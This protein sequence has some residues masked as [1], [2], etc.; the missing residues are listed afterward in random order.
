MTDQALLRSSNTFARAIT[1][2]GALAA[3]RA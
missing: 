3:L 1:L 2:T